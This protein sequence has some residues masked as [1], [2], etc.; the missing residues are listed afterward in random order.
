MN[1][2]EPSPAAWFEF[3]KFAVTFTPAFN[4]LLI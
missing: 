1:V 4:Q 3:T 2:L